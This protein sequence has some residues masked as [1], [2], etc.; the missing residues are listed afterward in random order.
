MEQLSII[1]I[2]GKIIE[3]PQLLEKTLTAFAKVRG[4]K[5]LVHGGGKTATEIGKQLGVPSQ[6]VNGRRITSKKNLDVNIM[7][8]A[9][10]LNKNMVAQLQALGCN[11]IGLTGADAN[12]ISAQ[13]RP[14]QPIDFGFV[15]DITQVNTKV[16]ST[17]L[18]A[19]ICPVLCAITH[20]NSGQLLNSNAD[21]VA[22]K[23]AAHM[24]SVCTTE[25]CYVFEHAGVL[26]QLD[27]PDSVV[28]WIA[29]TPDGKSQQA[30]IS[31]GMVAKFECAIEALQ[32][33]L[34]KVKIGDFNM[35]HGTN[36]GTTLC[37]TQQ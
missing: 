37:M 23:V 3:D 33:G 4:K 32:A 35:I 5:I 34:E 13:R 8:F 10:L 19:G 11:A 31:D 1:K 14:A 15:G 7:A 12:V 36:K 25:L 18:D 9:G 30:N 27:Q 2:G 16:L 6:F 20:D 21:G 28:P 26:E 17:L 24:Q 29:I 22:S